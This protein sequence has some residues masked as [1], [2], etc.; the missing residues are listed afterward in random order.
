MAQH[1][2][3]R[4]QLLPNVPRSCLTT[5]PRNTDS[6]KQGEYSIYR[7]FTWKEAPYRNSLH[8]ANKEVTVKRYNDKTNLRRKAIVV[9]ISDY[10][11][12]SASCNESPHPTSGSTSSQPAPSSWVDCRCLDRLAVLWRPK[13]LAIIQLRHRFCRFTATVFLAIKHVRSGAQRRPR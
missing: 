12:Y 4:H 3:G 8:I 13:E 10:L 9:C 11:F 2:A 1:A 6:S 5:N 7:Q